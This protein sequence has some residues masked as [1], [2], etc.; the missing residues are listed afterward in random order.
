MSKLPSIV[1]KLPNDLRNF[2]DRVRE[3]IGS[4]DLITRQDLFRSGLAKPGGLGGLDLLPADG[5]ILTPPA[6]TNVRVFSGLATIIVEF[7]YPEYAGHAYAEIWRSEEDDLGTAVVIGQ[8]PGSLYADPVGGGQ[9]YYYW[10]RFVSVTDTSG[11]FNKTAGTFGEVGYDPGYLLDIL[12]GEIT[13]SQLYSALGE[14]IDNIAANTSAIVAEAVTRDEETGRLF[15]QYTVKIDQNGYVSGYGLASTANNSTPYS[16]F[17]VRADRFY[18]ASPSGPGITPTLPFIVQTTPTTIGGVPVPVGTYINDAFIRNGSISNAKIGLAV[19]DD[20]KIANLSAVKV[21]FGEMLG[22]RIKVNTLNADRITVSSLAARLA[23][24][25][26]AYITQANIENAAITTAKIYDLAVTNAKIANAAITN[27]KIE[28]AAITNAKIQNLAVDNAKIANLAVT[29]AKI[30]NLSVDSAKIANLAVDTAKIRDL[31]VDTAK[32]NDLAVNTLKIGGDQVSII[33]SGI[34]PFYIDAGPLGAKVSI[35]YEAF[36]D[37]Y[38]LSL[39][40]SHGV[41]SHATVGQ[42]KATST[43]ISYSAGTTGGDADMRMY[44]RK[45]IPGIAAGFV[46]PGSHYVGFTGGSVVVTISKR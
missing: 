5:D 37:Q 13:E 30:A 43:N 42:I 33:I 26:T 19:I 24:I 29:N 40:S 36:P 14:K 38:G 3:A 7:D 9:S 15:A 10:V 28:N 32:I 6:P 22:A 31:A 20:A 16:E 34:Y 4:G 35:M 1:S 41:E 39:N 46:G 21:T 12:E 25:E 44:G 27:A 11:P 8:T 17:A 23:Y 18:I 45:A 2:L